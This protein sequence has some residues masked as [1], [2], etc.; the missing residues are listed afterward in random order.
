MALFSLTGSPSTAPLPDSPLEV[1][2]AGRFPDIDFNVLP[3]DQWEPYINA[4]LTE[5]FEDGWQRRE[6]DAFVGAFVLGIAVTFVSQWLYNR[7]K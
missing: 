5:E 7:R 4:L 3:S 1:R 2:L 6:H